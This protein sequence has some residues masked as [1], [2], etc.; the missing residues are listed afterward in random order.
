LGRRRSLGIPLLLSFGAEVND[1]WRPWN[2]RWN[3]A[4]QTD[5]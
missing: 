1:E 3:G 4:D 2:A 5:G